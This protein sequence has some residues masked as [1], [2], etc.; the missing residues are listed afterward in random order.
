M[1]IG[2]SKLVIR[3]FFSVSVPSKNKRRP[4]LPERL[5]SKSFVNETMLLE[6]FAKC[7]L[8][9]FGLQPTFQMPP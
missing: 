4:F 3:H 5:F 1:V 6:A 8:P 9:Q 7:G 2:N